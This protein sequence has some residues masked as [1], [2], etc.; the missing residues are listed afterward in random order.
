MY[1]ITSLCSIKNEVQSSKCKFL[2]NYT[3]TYGIRCSSIIT[4]KNLGYLL[5][6]FISYSFRVILNSFFEFLPTGF[7]YNIVNFL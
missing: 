7:K 3:A 6:F 5:P 2:L 4:P 1:M